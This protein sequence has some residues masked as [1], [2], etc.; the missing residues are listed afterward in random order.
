M[1]KAMPYLRVKKSLGLVVALALIFTVIVQQA[2]AYEV[3]K[4][5]IVLLIAKDSTGRP[6]GTGTGFIVKPE[7]V[8]VTNYH[9]LVDAA[10]VEAVMKGGDRVQAETIL[11]IDRV[12]DFALL[13][14]AKG[15][16]STLEI[17][18]SDQLNEF[19]Y[20]SALGFLSQNVNPNKKSGKNIVLQTYGFVLGIHPQAYPEFSFIYTTAS[21]G[22]GFSGGPVVNKENRVVGIATVEGR[23]I[24][25]ALPINFIKP[26]L[27]TAE[28]TSFARFLKEEQHSKEAHYYRGNHLLHTMG[29]PEGAAREFKTVL[30][31][32]DSFVLAHYDLAAAYQ[33]QGMTDRAI[34]EYEKT[35]TLNPMFP[36]GASNLGGYYFRIQKYEEAVEM[37]EQAIRAYPNFIQAHS[38][39]GAVLN[40]LG[41]SPEAE[42][43]LEKALNLDPKFGLAYFN[44]GNTHMALDHLD[45]AREAYEKSVENGIDFLSL[46]WN[47]YKI[48]HRQEKR[49][50]AI[51]EL[52]IILQID[53]LNLDAQKKLKELAR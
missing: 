36:E 23:A 17:G 22:P 4:N 1:F 14:L 46:H 27:S 19:D 11:K 9:V 3:N 51:K 21:F 45:E 8:L 13:K 37:F 52:N 32:D 12:K 44:L 53:P 5:A 26:F 47:L 6:L 18:D 28:G 30:K 15:T 43:H 34:E 41:R 38:N 35:L 2:L 33:N 20:L 42:S 48:Y 16:Y 24:N 29:N 50:E 7:G 25:L 39:L 49:Q 31:M 40:K 10:S